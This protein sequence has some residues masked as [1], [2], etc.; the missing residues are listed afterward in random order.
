M[1]KKKA[2]SSENKADDV[3]SNMPRK[4]GDISSE[5]LALEQGNLYATLMEVQQKLAMINGELRRR[6]ELKG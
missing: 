4:I 3:V 1:S 6:Q 2:K 5:E